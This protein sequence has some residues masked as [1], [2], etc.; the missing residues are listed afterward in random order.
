MYDAAMSEATQIAFQVSA[1]DLER[2]DAMVP[3]QFPSRA[4][5]LR[6]AVHDWLERRRDEQIDQALERGYADV[7]EDDELTTA[8]AK[9]SRRSL[10]AADLDW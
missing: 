1:T 6:S 2:I 3:D 9:A 10:E 7:P 8:M 4:A 5:A